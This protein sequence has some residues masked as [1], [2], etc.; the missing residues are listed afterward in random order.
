[1]GS[2]RNIMTHRPKAMKSS[3]PTLGL[4]QSTKFKVAYFSQVL[5]SLTF[6][7]LAEE[8]T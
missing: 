8:M 2:Q 3:T 5:M 1:M 6:K 7:L 4:E